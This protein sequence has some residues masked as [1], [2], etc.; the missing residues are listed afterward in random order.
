M[1]YNESEDAYYIQHGADSA[2][3]KLGSNMEGKIL[4]I[5]FTSNMIANSIFFFIRIIDDN[6]DF[7]VNVPS[8]SAFDFDVFGKNM[9]RLRRDSGGYN[10]S[11]SALQNLSCLIISYNSYQTEQVTFSKNDNIALSYD[12]YVSKVY[13]FEKL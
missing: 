6:I 12:K 8:S 2:L 3:K 1:I 4:M 5:H 7:L 10:P 9:I 13:L 11:V